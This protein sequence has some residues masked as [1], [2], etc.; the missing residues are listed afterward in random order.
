MARNSL[1]FPLIVALPK[2]CTF[3]IE[4]HRDNI[5]AALT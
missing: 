5:L 3:N 1:G 2:G 4:C